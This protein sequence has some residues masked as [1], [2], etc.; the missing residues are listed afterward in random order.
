MS[1]DDGLE[2]Q[3]YEIKG[4]LEIRK[5]L[6][7]NTDWDFEFR[8]NEKYAYDLCIHQWNDEP[9]GPDDNDVVGYIELERARKDK[10][11]SWVTGDV[12]E[13]WHF[14]SF[15]ERKIRSYDYERGCWTG[16]QGDHDRTVYI[17][18]NHALDNCF[19]A[20]ITTI[21]RDGQIT[22]RS[23]GS[24]KNTYRALSLYNDSVAVGIADTI[25]LVE[26][27]LGRSDSNQETLFDF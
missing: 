9:A 23:D 17:K 13:G 14:Y 5:L 18:F 26:D 20:P 16:L 12:P 8:K 27:W 4:E 6:E 15:L 19:T 21:Y 3:S 10:S 24:P 1:L 7:S 11:K 22:K 2:K 25:D